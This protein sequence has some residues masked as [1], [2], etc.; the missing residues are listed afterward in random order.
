VRSIA[1]IAG[2]TLLALIGA[3]VALALHTWY[4]KPLSIDWFYARAFLQQWLDQPEYLTHLRI[5][6]P[7]GIRGHNARLTDRSIAHDEQAAARAAQSLETLESYDA[8]GAITRA[9]GQARVNYEIAR[10]HWRQQAA[11]GRWLYHDYQLEQMQG[12]HTELPT[13]I[14]QV[15]DIRD[16]TDAGHYLAR[17]A[18]IP[19]FADQF[20]EGLRQREARGIRPPKFAVDKSVAQ[21]EEF[22]AG[23][24]LLEDFTEKIS[25]LSDESQRRELRADAQ[26]IIATAVVPAYRRILDYARSLAGRVTRN[27]GVWALPDGAAY[28]Q[29]AIERHTTTTMTADEI[30]RLGLAEVARIGTAMDALLTAAGYTTGTRAE[31]LAALTSSPAQQYPADDSGRAAILRDYKAIID[32]ITL[33]LGEAF[34]TLPQAKVVLKRVPAFSENGEAS[35]SYRP[36]ALDGSRPGVFYVNLRDTRETPRF[37]MRTLAYHEANPGHHLQSAIAAELT[38]LPLFRNVLSFTAYAE[39]WALYAERLAWELGYQRNPL[40]NLGRLRDEMLR[41]ARLV[42]DTGLHE[43]RWTRERAIDYM[44]AETGWPPSVVETEIERYLVWPGQ[45]LAY[46]VGMIKF[47]ELRERAQATL[48]EEFDL[49]EFHDVVL[50]NGEMPLAVLELVV[51]DW[52]AARVAPAP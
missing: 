28:Y 14:M 25:G 23:D 42:V 1:R 26:R 15:H 10:Y 12:D 43:K 5:L 30:H 29:Y 40:D 34:A 50:R 48:G 24:L 9:G 27:D 18:A 37:S 16:T 22:L 6:E 39:G 11:G 41:A 31:Q 45:A 17:L 19:A 49:R 52:I 2:F 51:D 7:W 20:I 21:I 46:K 35:A 13:F 47:L 3:A 4:G 36:P 33:N 44:I 38:G 8:R 32:E